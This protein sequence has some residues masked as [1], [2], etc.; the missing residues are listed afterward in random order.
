MQINDSVEIPKGNTQKGVNKT[1][2]GMLKN[3]YRSFEASGEIKHLDVPC[4]EGHLSRCLIQTFPSLKVT[5][6][7][8]FSKLKGE[9]QF[10]HHPV[11]AHQYLRL[12]KPELFQSVTCVSGV[13]CFDGVE[14]LFSEIH[15]V[16]KPG[17]LFVITNDNVLTVRDRLNFIFFGRLKRFKL[18]YDTFEGNWNVVLPQ[19]LMMHFERQKFTQMDVKYTAY[20]TEDFL[21]IPIALLIYPFFFLNILKSKSPWTL[22]QKLKLFPFQSLIS[23]HYVIQG[24]K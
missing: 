17:G 20:Y 10:E 21:L 24:I 19:G 3:Y 16:L 22:K 23:R 11:A 1:V 9:T 8:P 4:G 6:V 14:E 7:D 5:G 18:F 13:M 2:L 15:R 12:Q